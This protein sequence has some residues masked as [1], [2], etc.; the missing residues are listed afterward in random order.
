MVGPVNDS[1]T[2]TNVEILRVY[3][4]EAEYEGNDL[5]LGKYLSTLRRPNGLTDLEYHR[6][7]KKAKL[8][9]VRDG[10]L[11]KKGRIPQQ[12]IGL[13]DQKLEI[14]KEIHDEIGHKG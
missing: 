9:I 1:S 6:L 13:Q 2:G 14:M 5:I 3:L 12:V 11:Y 7:R 10:Y 4:N 8:F